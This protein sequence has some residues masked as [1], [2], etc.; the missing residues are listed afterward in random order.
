MP[1]RARVK[2]PDALHARPANLLVRLAQ[3]FDALVRVERGSCGADACKILDVLALGA[4][5]GDEV[6]ISAEGTD[7]ADALEAI[8][9]LIARNFD[10][11]LVPEMG[12]AVVEGIAIGNAVVWSSPT[13]Q[14]GSTP[15][16]E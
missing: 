5:K 2:L 11:D 4:A 1:V 15:K 13:A 10:A 12:S 6:D 14:Q 7:A 16:R 3:Q 8:R 9:T